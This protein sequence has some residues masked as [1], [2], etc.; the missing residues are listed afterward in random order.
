MTPPNEIALS[1]I[2]EKYQEITPPPP[3]PPIEQFQTSNSFKF[4]DSFQ[5]KLHWS[6]FSFKNQQKTLT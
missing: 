2:L 4:N 5:K 6:V 1:L 3:L